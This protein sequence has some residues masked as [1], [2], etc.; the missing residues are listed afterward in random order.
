[1]GQHSEFPFLTVKKVAQILDVHVDTVYN[2]IRS[3]RIHARKLTDNGDYRVRSSDFDAYVASVFDSPEPVPVSAKS[4]VKEA[5]VASMR[6]AGAKRSF[7][8]LGRQRAAAER[9]N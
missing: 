6:Q 5:T 9:M 3:G 2:L 7:F 4:P 1:M 8:E